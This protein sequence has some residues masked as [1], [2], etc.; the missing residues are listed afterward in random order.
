LLRVLSR[1]EVPLHHHAVESDLREYLK[2]R[3]SRGGTR[4]AAGRR[5]RDRL[6]RWKQTGRQL[7]VRFWAYLPDRVRGWGPIPR[8]AELLKRQAGAMPATPVVAVP[9]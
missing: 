1:P 2:R 3:Q 6:A 4:S 7:G 9:A 8:L 5:G